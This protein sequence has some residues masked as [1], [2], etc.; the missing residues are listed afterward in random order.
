MKDDYQA[1]KRSIK[2]QTKNRPKVQ[3]NKPTVATEG[4]FTPLKQLVQGK[5]H[6]RSLWRTPRS[7]YFIKIQIRLI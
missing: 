6:L 4:L 7:G 1:K 2:A 5:F 3:D